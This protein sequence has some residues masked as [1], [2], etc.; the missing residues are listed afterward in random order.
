MVSATTVREIARDDLCRSV[1]FTLTR[2]D[3]ERGDGLS[4]EGYGAVFDSVTVIDSW[5][6]RFEEVVARGAFRKSLRERP[7]KFQFDHGRHPLI[8]SIPIGAFEAG[9]PRED[10]RGLFVRARLMDNWLIQ[11][12]RDACANESIDG[13][14]FRFSVVQE[15]WR[16]AKGRKLTDPEEIW[17]GIFS[18][19][20]D[21][22][23]RRTLK[24]VK[25]LEVGPVVWPAYDDTT[26]GVRSKTITIDL[27]RL[28]D[29]DTRRALAQAV[30]LAERADTKTPGHQA[31]TEGPQANESTPDDHPAGPVVSRDA[32]GE[33]P[34][35]PT[36]ETRR[37][38]L[39]ASQIE[40]WLQSRQV[41]VENAMRK[42]ASHGG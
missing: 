36:T 31:G 1:S 15:E 29:P 21:G 26:A 2:E 24:E 41:V 4:F 16:D 13:M 19:T 39:R 38:A 27:G 30:F 32:S 22:L 8:G 3:G 33:H 25:L 9:Y 5:E 6:G 10:D 23:L 28:D 18:P 34:A 14:S 42:G 35:T 17:R 7:P 40:A 20:D 12:I 11:P 37:P